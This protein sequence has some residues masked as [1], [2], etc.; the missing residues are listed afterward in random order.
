[1][2]RNNPARVIVIGHWNPATTYRPSI[3]VLINMA[4]FLDT[5]MGVMVVVVGQLQYLSTWQATVLT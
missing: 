4:V 3:I 2:K 5:P 1:M